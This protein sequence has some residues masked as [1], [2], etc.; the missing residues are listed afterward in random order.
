MYDIEEDNIEGMSYPS[1]DCF[2]NGTDD[3]MEESNLLKPGEDSP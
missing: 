3:N 2:S 1:V